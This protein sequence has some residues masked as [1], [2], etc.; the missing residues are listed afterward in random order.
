MQ[1]SLINTLICPTTGKSL[2]LRESLRERDEV[3]EGCL[4]CEKTGQSFPIKKGIPY[5][6][7]EAVMADITAQRFGYQWK[8]Q[9][10][11]FF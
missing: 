4:I 5:F 7:P 2:Q 6:A 1:A 11:G 9:A 3:V 10:I 8:Q